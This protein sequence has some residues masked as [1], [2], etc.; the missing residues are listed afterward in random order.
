MVVGV[1]AFVAE[2][3]N[4]DPTT[5]GVAFTLVLVAL[6]LLAGM[7]AP[8]P[9]RSACVTALVLAV[10]LVWLFAFLGGGDVGQDEFRGVYL[11]TLACYALL[12][13][14]GGRRDV[15]SSSPAR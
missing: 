13:F 9:M 2:A 3:N 14:S 8:G 11:L 12:F 15:P 6:A 1:V 5:P 7:R 4:D 10:P